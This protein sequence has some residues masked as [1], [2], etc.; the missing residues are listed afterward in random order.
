MSTVKVLF[1]DR[2]LRDD[3]FDINRQCSYIDDFIP[4]NFAATTTLYYVKYYNMTQTS[5]KSMNKSFV[6]KESSK[7]SKEIFCYFIM[8]GLYLSLS[9]MEIPLKPSKSLILDEMKYTFKVQ[10][11]P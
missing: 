4:Q 8:R 9:T 11:D 3:G 10:T 7:I 6:F 2:T 5:L 1:E